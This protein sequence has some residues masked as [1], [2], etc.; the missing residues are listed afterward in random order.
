MSRGFWTAIGAI[1]GFFIGGMLGHAAGIARSHSVDDGGW[2]AI[3]T[4]VGLILGGA[5]VWL[6]VGRTK[7]RP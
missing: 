3:G 2:G 7:S 6:V 5:V 4:L 1:V